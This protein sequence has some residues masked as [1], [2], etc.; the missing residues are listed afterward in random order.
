MLNLKNNRKMKI[1][2]INQGRLFR[3]EMKN[4]VGGADICKDHLFGK[5][6]AIILTDCKGGFQYCSSGDTLVESCKIIFK[7]TVE[8]GTDEKKYNQLCT[9]LSPSTNIGISFVIVN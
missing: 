2:L 3:E 8:C 7:G 1:N 9:I 6:C 4:I 5:P